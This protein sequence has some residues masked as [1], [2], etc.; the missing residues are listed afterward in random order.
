MKLLRN[1][2]CARAVSVALV[3]MLCYITI[4]CVDLFRFDHQELWLL[5]LAGVVVILSAVFAVGNPYWRGFAFG[6]G[7]RKT[8]SEL[9]V[10]WVEKQQIRVCFVTT[11]GCLFNGVYSV[12]ERKF[13][14]YDGLSFELKEIALWRYETDLMPFI[15]HMSM[16][17]I[18]YHK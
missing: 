12:P 10:K 3:S 15:D 16:T 2:L 13:H 8:C 9:P 4:E 11:D 14:G 17:A 6:D 18:R 7:W 1:A 5:L